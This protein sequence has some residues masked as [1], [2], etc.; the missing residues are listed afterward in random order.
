[1]WVFDVRTGRILR[2]SP[3]PEPSRKPRNSPQQ[4][5][6]A[7]ERTGVRQDLKGELV[8]NKSA[9]AGWIGLQNTKRECRSNNMLKLNSQSLFSTTFQAAW[10]LKCSC[11]PKLFVLKL[12]RKQCQSFS[13]WLADF[14]R[15]G[16]GLTQSRFCGGHWRSSGLVPKTSSQTVNALHGRHRAGSFR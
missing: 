13:F 11:G 3:P 15:L 1:M 16:G 9:G 4:R 14:L 5:F 7:C 10:M 8:E 6:S 12:N 2:S